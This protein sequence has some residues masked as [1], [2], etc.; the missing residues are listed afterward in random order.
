M[1]C[2][3]VKKQGPV[4]AWREESEEGVSGNGEKNDSKSDHE[5]K[6]MACVLLWMAP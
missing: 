3:V 6:L 4:L 2:Q 5:T 1:K